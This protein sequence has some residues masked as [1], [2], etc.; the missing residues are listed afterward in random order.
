[1]KNGSGNLT[2]TG[3]STFSGGTTL[4]AGALNFSNGSLGTGLITVAGNNTTLRWNAGSTQ[5]ISTQG[6]KLS[7]AIAAIFDTNGNTVTLASA[8]QTGPSGTASLNKV[9]TGALAR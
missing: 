4:N 7:D 3:A 5:D 6:L 2:L 1:M 8:L 9:G